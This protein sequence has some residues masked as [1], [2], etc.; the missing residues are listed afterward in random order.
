VLIVVIPLA[1]FLLLIGL[2]GAVVIQRFV[3]KASDP[4][5]LAMVL[6]AMAFSTYTLAWVLTNSGTG[7]STSTGLGLGVA[8]G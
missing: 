6:G 3:R 2:I 7:T 8:L 1:D 5:L 4:R